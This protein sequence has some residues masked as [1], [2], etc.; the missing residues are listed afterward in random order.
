M[1]SMKYDYEAINDRLH[2]VIKGTLISP[3][4]SKELTMVVDTG[5]DHIYISIFQI[6]KTL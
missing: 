4:K 6:S 3:S 1:S 2:P 5:F